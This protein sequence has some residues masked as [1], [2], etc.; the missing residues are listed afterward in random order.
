VS[1]TSLQWPC[2]E[3]R[4]GEPRVRIEEAEKLYGQVLLSDKRWV[5]YY[6]Q[7]GREVFTETFISG[8]AFPGY[9]RRKE[10]IDMTAMHHTEENLTLAYR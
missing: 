9:H 1:P 5:A 7:T 10:N 3:I 8:A 4:V 2:E 6:V